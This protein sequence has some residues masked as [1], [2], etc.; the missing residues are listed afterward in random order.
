VISRN[1]HTTTPAPAAVS[2]DDDERGPSKSQKKRDMLK[3]QALGEELLSLKETHWPKMNLEEPLLD[4]LLASKAVKG[5]EA[6][7]RHRQLV[8]KL[9]RGINAVAIENYLNQL[10][11]RKPAKGPIKKTNKPIERHYRSDRVLADR[12]EVKADS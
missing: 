9:M 10:P 8:G 5:H 11:Q 4:A 1:L 2:D 7:R 3:L 6:I 12:G